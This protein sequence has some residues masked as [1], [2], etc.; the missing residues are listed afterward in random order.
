MEEE[1]NKCG[2]PSENGKA[3]EMDSLSETLEG[4]QFADL[5]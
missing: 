4:A 1:K 3:K 2:Q 5:F